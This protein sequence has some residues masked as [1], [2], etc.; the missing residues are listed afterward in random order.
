M[1][2]KIEKQV[3]AYAVVSVTDGFV[4]TLEHTRESARQFK[5]AYEKYD[6]SIKYKIIKLKGDE[7]VR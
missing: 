2:K 4:S 3:V 5:R 1:T 7:I 6:N